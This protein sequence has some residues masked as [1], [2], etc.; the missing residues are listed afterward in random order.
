MLRNSTPNARK[1]VRPADT[2][3]ALH[4]HAFYLLSIPPTFLLLKRVWQKR[5]KFLLEVA[6]SETLPSLRHVAVEL[7]LVHRQMR[8]RQLRD[9][10]SQKNPTREIW[11]LFIK[12]DKFSNHSENLFTTST[13]WVPFG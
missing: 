2:R 10:E 13:L 4:A 3:G 1:L 11:L 9:S 12:I 8:S 6:R 5:G 7:A